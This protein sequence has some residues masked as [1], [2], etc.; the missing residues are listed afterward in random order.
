MSTVRRIDVPE[1][2]SITSLKWNQ[3]QKNANDTTIT[4]VL[5]GKADKGEL[6]NDD[7]LASLRESEVGEYGFYTGHVIRYG[8]DKYDEID[9]T[10]T[11]LNVTLNSS[12]YYS[13][14]EAS[15]RTE[16]RP[17]EEKTDII[18]TTG[19]LD[20]IY[21]TWWNHKVVSTNKDET[22]VT[23]GEDTDDWTI[24]TDATIPSG[25]SVNPPTARWIKSNQALKKG[26]Y[27]ILDA[28]FPGVQS[29]GVGARQV[30]E[31]MYSRSLSVVKSLVD[32][33]GYLKAPQD[34]NDEYYD[35][36][37][38]GQ[39]PT[40]WLITGASYVKRFGWYE[41]QLTFAYAKGGWLDQETDANTSGVYPL[42]T[43]L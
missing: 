9:I 25:Y 7:I 37:A 21:V 17:L 26:E 22:I 1:L 8:W 2:G 36:S 11:D 27:V 23:T 28:R 18:A 20:E 29:Y 30:K 34:S 24:I 10:C 32:S 5:K 14:F 40:K 35:N 31:I 19:N 42:F 16:S 39:D 38:L 15:S 33:V 12:G 41:A 13:R 4:T 3:I 43:S 6:I